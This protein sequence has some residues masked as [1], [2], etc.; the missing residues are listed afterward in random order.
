MTMVLYVSI[1]LLATLTALPSDS[2]GHGG[3]HSGVHGIGLVALIWGTSVG[4]ALAHWFSFRLTARAFGGGEVSERDVKIGLAQMGGA[5]LV[6]LL[7]TIPV[8]VAGERNDVRV[9]SWV[10]ALIVGFAGYVVSRAS[11]RARTQSLIV[12]GVVMVM[13]FAVAAVKNFL[14][15]H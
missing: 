14:L 13:G 11:G 5:V 2:E 8:L 3:G 6:A 12:G 1:V 10:P 9:T 4:L 15:G 7:C